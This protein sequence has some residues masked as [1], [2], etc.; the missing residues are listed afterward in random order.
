MQTSGR[1]CPYR[2]GAKYLRDKGC[3]VY[4]QTAR[5]VHRNCVVRHRNRDQQNATSPY[6]P[7]HKPVPRSVFRGHSL[8]ASLGLV[9]YSLTVWPVLASEYTRVTAHQT[10][11]R[12]NGIYRGPTK[13]GRLQHSNSCCRSKSTMHAGTGVSVTMLHH[14]HTIS[15]Q[16]LRSIGILQTLTCT[17]WSILIDISQAGAYTVINTRML[18]VPLTKNTIPC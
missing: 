5:S 13:Q 12:L 8:G 16:C 6:C 9:D 18:S 15:I 2:D 10:Q 17:C 14:L 4:I 11:G 7:L 1:H 3:S